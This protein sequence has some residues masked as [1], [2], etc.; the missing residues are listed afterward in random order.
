MIK[1]ILRILT[2]IAIL[3]F[4]AIPIYA[5]DSVTVTVNSVPQFTQGITSFTVIYAKDT[6][7]DLAWTYDATVQKVMVR[8][9]YGDYPADIPN[10]VTTP[11]DGY[12]VY[13]GSG[14]NFSDTSMNLDETTA[15]LNYKAW[16]QKLDGT[17]YTTTSTNKQESIE[18]LLLAL[19]LLPAILTGLG[20]CFKQNILKTFGALFWL[21]FFFY[22]AWWYPNH[23]LFGNFDQNFVSLIGVGVF[24]GI[25]FDV[26]HGMSL[27][28]RKE[29]EEKSHKIVDSDDDW[30]DDSDREYASD[31]RNY[32][33]QSKLYHTVSRRRRWV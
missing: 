19:L 25:M 17:W 30:E 7:M 26:I 15:T 9:K 3:L 5:G 24:I 10:D 4:Q 18:M 14:N 8:A 22:L 32:N 12:L 13:Y 21:A 6:Q 31:Q 27:S 29:Q 2:V 11:T 28:K 16:A 23:N 20:Y 1:R 33:K